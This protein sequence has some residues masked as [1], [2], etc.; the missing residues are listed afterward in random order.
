MS[1][2]LI[3]LI[4]PQSGGAFPVFE[5]IDGYG[6]YQVQPTTIAR[7]AIPTLNRK[8]GMLVFVTGTNA[9]YQ[10]DS[11]LTTWTTLP[12]GAAP[13][14]GDLTGTLPNPFVKSLTGPDGYVLIPSPELRFVS[15][16]G[17][18]KTI[19]MT[20][21]SDLTL[22]SSLIIQAANNVGPDYSA[23][24]SVQILGGQGGAGGGISLICGDGTDPI[25][26]GGGI[27]MTAGHAQS[28]GGTVSISAGYASGTSSSQGGSF[29]LTA[30]DS[31]GD[32][33]LG[34]EFN[35]RSGDGNGGGFVRITSGNTVTAGNGGNIVVTSGDGDLGAGSGGDLN[36][37]LGT[38]AN[39]G[40]YVHRSGQ[41]FNGGVVR[42]YGGDS[43]GAGQ[44]GNI[45]LN[46]GVSGDN[47][48]G[49]GV[50]I[51][52]GAAGTNEGGTGGA[53]TISPGDTPSTST[54]TNMPDVTIG[55]DN[56]CALVVRARNNTGTRYGFLD[57]TRLGIQFKIQYISS[58]DS[59]SISIFIN[60][61]IVVDNRNY[62][63]GQTLFFPNDP[64]IQDG[65]LLVIRNRAASP[66][67]TTLNGNGNTI[68]D[69][70]TGTP[71]ATVT[72][73]TRDTFNFVYSAGVWV[74]Y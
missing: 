34:G 49:G 41:G 66:T 69:P 23:G 31:G 1:I 5:D 18:N 24:G 28:D 40:S 52:G 32:I 17:S 44:A 46:A 35:I 65:Q 19:S 14:G 61:Y 45:Y 62:G 15:T 70:V 38:G 58:G 2:S 71:G 9:F 27:L 29:F 42:L 25:G 73:S 43:T 37:S 10:L 56:N 60:T 16:A 7:D 22:T 64:F 72:I 54:T 20:D 63:G 53:V 26:D 50:F 21:I 11:N 8:A 74:Y 47:G 30:G 57:S 6:G 48:I 39:G 4:K 36:V 67:V 51:A 33:S 55:Y 3:S 13:A 12:L 59:S 68:E